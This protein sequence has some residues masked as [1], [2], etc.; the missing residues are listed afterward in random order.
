MIISEELPFED[1]D[2]PPVLTSIFNPDD[3]NKNANV[4]L[5]SQLFWMRASEIFPAEEGGFDILPD[6][7]R[8]E[9]ILQGRLGDCY[10]I[11]C[12]SSLAAKPD[13]IRKLFV[14]TKPNKSGCYVV[15]MCVNGTW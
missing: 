1:V 15:K 7:I 4:Q 2:F 12:L 5:Y 9:D 8:E 10:F 14:T 3:Y 11:Q 6:L 13:R